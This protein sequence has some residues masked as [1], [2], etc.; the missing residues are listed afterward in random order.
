MQRSHSDGECNSLGLSGLASLN[1]SPIGS[2]ENLLGVK[3]K[4]PLTRQYGVDVVD[5]D[6]D[7]LDVSQN[8]EVVVESDNLYDPLSS[9][10]INN[11]RR[12]SSVNDMYQKKLRKSAHLDEAPLTKGSF[13]NLKK[14]KSSSQRRK[15]FAKSVLSSRKFIAADPGC[16]NSSG[17]SASIKS[18]QCSVTSFSSVDSQSVNLVDKCVNCAFERRKS[19]S[20]KKSLQYASYHDTYGD[21]SSRRSSRHESSC[22]SR[23][24]SMHLTSDY[25]TGSYQSNSSYHSHRHHHHHHRHHRSRRKHRCRNPHHHHHNHDYN[26]DEDP[27]SD[28]NYYERRKTRLPHWQ[29]QGNSSSGYSMSVT[30]EI[31]SS[32]RSADS[33]QSSLCSNYS[34]GGKYNIKYRPH[35]NLQRCESYSHSHSLLEPVDIDIANNLHHSHRPIGK[36]SSCP[37]SG[38]KSKLTSS[39][40]Q[41][42]SPLFSSTEF[43]FPGVNTGQSREVKSH[44]QIPVLSSCE[45]SPNSISVQTDFPTSIKVNESDQDLRA[46]SSK[47]NSVETNQQSQED[48]NFSPNRSSMDSAYQSIEH[49]LSKPSSSVV[50]PTSSIGFF[51]FKDTDPIWS[52]LDDPTPST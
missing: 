46:S 24:G 40:D 42:T 6:N 34:V 50:S 16:N 18:G 23:K 45:L 9:S 27:E 43:K 8:I 48:R 20:L 17:G 41:A 30:D 5:S 49:G 26:E 11:I 33:R 15:D 4:S 28:G 35:R 32:T 22:S 29:Q 10:G 36:Q 51:R 21:T 3:K 25:S 44:L 39:T 7:I 1:A 14:K 52:V 19:K 31:A 47:L 13:P 37:I 2:T 12:V 38:V